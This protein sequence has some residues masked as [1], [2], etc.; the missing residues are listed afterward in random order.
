MKGAKR[1]IG[2]DNVPERLDFAAT[3]SNIEVIDFSKH[4]DVVKRL[5]ELVPGGV[6]VAIDAGK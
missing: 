5:Q 1:V 3:R 2:I 6:D 4:K